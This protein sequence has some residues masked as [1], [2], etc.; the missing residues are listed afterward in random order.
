MNHKIPFH[1]FPII[2]AIQGIEMRLIL[3]DKPA[4]KNFPRVLS[5]T[6]HPYALKKTA[7]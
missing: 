4:E 6:F 1:N 5:I 7:A 3:A 2:F